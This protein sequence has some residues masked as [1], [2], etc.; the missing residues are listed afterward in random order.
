MSSM[1]AVQISTGF[2]HPII[3]F[4][5][6]LKPT[7]MW[8]LC[9]TPACTGKYTVGM[10]QFSC[11]SNCECCRDVVLL[12][13]TETGRISPIRWIWHFQEELPVIGGFLCVSGS[14]HLIWPPP[15]STNFS[16]SRLLSHLLLPTHIICLCNTYLFP[17]WITKKQIC[18]LTPLSL[19]HMFCA[20]W[21]QNTDSKI[22]KLFLRLYKY[23]YSCNFCKIVL[24]Y[25]TWISSIPSLSSFMSK[26][27]RVKVHE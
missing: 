18:Y 12:W 14:R 17:G 15:L 9:R 19:L 10:I 3:H 22:F 21:I 24:K 27:M 13:G 2:I 1:S 20:V 11:E 23:R 4:D 7:R 16:Y 25:S 5:V 26:W 8:C 6:D